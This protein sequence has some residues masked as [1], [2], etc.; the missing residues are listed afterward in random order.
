MVVKG[1]TTRVLACVVFFCFLSDIRA[2]AKANTSNQ[3]RSKEKGGGGIASF[4]PPP[5]TPLLPHS[6]Y[7]FY[8]RFRPMPALDFVRLMDKRKQKGLLRML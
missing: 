4:P 3:N 1:K 2:G 6:S 7:F 8:A 5:Y